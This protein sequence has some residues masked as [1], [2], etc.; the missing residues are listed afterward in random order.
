MKP[1]PTSDEVAMLLERYAQGERDFSGLS[2]SECNLAGVKLPHIIL[3]GATLKV[4]NL[5][6]ANLSQ[7]DLTRAVLNVSRMS[8]IN[9]SQANLHQA[10]LNV[11]NL[12]RAVLVGA[13]LSNASLVRSELLRADLSNANLSLAN[14]QEA[15]LREARLRWANLDRVN[16][17][18]CNLRNSNLMGANLNHA[19]ANSINLE[20][21]DLSGATLIAA[22][23]RHA[24]LRMANLSG[25]N[26]RG[27][28]LR[29]A[30]LNGAKL[31]EADLTDAKL[32]GAELIGAQLQG[33][34][35]ENTT[36]V[37]VDL[38]RANLRDVRCVGS[39][40]SGA[41]LTGAKMHGAIAYD[42]QTAEIVCEWLDLSPM[43][44]QSQRR[45]FNTG[46]DIHSF[47][48]QRPPQ[49]NIV[50]DAVMTP[51]EHA[52]LATIFSTL[53]SV[54]PLFSRSPNVEL[55]NRHTVLTFKAAQEAE[56]LAITYLATWPFQDGERVQQ[57][58]IKLMEQGRA[59]PQQAFVQEESQRE[60]DW[61]IDM[62][63]QQDFPA[64]SE[65]AHAHAFFTQPLQVR[66][67]NTHR[68]LLELY[69]NPRFGLR[70]LSSFEGMFPLDGPSDTSS[71]APSIEDY[72]AF[73]AAS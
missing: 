37:H 70:N 56:L 28:N 22:E 44:E 13:N 30:D 47:L 35:L 19:Q 15:D 69:S 14:C 18:Q 65:L 55:T 73:I 53:A 17:S 7:S 43:A 20:G 4:V 10:Q 12:I 3:R 54:S 32:S 2:L 62:L 36:L 52:A 38:S 42:V 59:L 48:N 5:S 51:S 31:Q 49:V 67:V 25:A 40:L 24:N 34:I 29:W 63:G 8:S 46:E 72:L 16:L 33:A 41:M 26:L 60:L 45:Y 39:D 11:A 1:P 6:T 9:L 23:C 64:M 57:T 50:V 21:A 71:P 27:A 68:S 66:L 61:V 58:L